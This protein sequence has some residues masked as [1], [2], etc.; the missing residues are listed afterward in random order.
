[1]IVDNMDINLAKSL[2]RLETRKRMIDAE[3]DLTRECEAII[4]LEHRINLLLDEIKTLRSSVETHKSFVEENQ[5]NLTENNNE[6]QRSSEI[7][8]MTSRL[9]A[10]NRICRRI[11]VSQSLKRYR[12]KTT[13]PNLS[14]LDASKTSCTRGQ[15]DVDM[16]TYRMVHELVASFE[17]IYQPMEVI[18]SKRAD[19]PYVSYA[20]LVRELRQSLESNH[21]EGKTVSDASGT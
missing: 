2:D 21:N 7:F 16:L 11:D 12:A 15:D 17:E 3:S 19:L 5:R 6:L 13:H 14:H 4:E 9:A 18:L 10:L 20:N 1:M 8:D